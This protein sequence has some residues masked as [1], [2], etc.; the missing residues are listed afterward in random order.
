MSVDA[1]PRS[2]DPPENAERHQQW[3]ILCRWAF[4]ESLRQAPIDVPS[5]SNVELTRQVFGGEAQ[6]LYLA[7]FKKRCV[8]EGLD[9]PLKKGSGTI[10]AKHPPGRAGRAGKWCLTPFCWSPQAPA[11]PPAFAPRHQLPGHAVGDPVPQR[12]RALGTGRW[13][14]G[15]GLVTHRVRPLPLPACPALEAARSSSV[16]CSIACIAPEPDDSKLGVC[17]HAP[18]ERSVAKPSIPNLRAGGPPPHEPHGPGHA[19]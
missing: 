6:E 3:N 2:T 12:S 4:C 5:D 17:A 16:R 11:I 10:C 13:Y 18:F 1:G 19:P 7:V 8:R 15:S 14:D 9:S